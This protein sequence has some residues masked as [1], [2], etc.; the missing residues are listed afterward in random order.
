MDSGRAEQSGPV[1]RGLRALGSLPRRDKRLVN[2]RRKHGTRRTRGGKGHTERGEGFLA[3]GVLPGRS[4]AA[5]LR[6]GKV[7]ERSLS[8]FHEELN[9]APGK[10]P[11]QVAQAPPAL[12]EHRMVV[13]DVLEEE[14][15]ALQSGEGFLHSPSV[16]RCPGAG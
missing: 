1:D 16:E 2:L 11:S 3:W 15:S 9:L 4:P 14:A 13:M 7:F 12:E 5:T 8:G 10:R 6:G